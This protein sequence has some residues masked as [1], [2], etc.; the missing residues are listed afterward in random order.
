LGL[1][2]SLALNEPY[3]GISLSILLDINNQLFFGTTWYY[4]IG[5][6]D[7]MSMDISCTYAL[8]YISFHLVI[9]IN[10]S[11]NR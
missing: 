3:F 10:Q 2:N 8:P 6:R 5:H 9:G 4:L 11:L 7:S 1:L